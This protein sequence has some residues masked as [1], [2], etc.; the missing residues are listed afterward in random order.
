MTRTRGEDRAETAKLNDGSKLVDSADKAA[1]TAA[2]Q[3]G[4]SGGDLQRDIGTSA[5]QR[6]LRDPAAHDGVTKGKHAAHGQG[7]REPHPARDVVT[8]R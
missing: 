2:G 6:Q 1:P 7:T 5:E 8:E 4:S 3:Q